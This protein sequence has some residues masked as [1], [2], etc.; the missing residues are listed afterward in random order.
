MKIDK[1]NRQNASSN[2]EQCPN[3]D[4]QRQLDDIEGALETLQDAC[5]RT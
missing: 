5:K 4:D 2:V 3:H 1:C